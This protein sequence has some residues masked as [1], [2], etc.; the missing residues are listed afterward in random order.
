MLFARVIGSL[1]SVVTV[2]VSI[3]EPVAGISFKPPTKIQVGAAPWSVA[4]QPYG[5][6]LAV[7]CY[8]G[9]NVQIFG[10]LETGSSIYLINDFYVSSPTFVTKNYCWGF[11]WLS[12]GSSPQVWEW[13]SAWPIPYSYAAGPDSRSICFGA[14][15]LGSD[16]ED[17]ALISFG[18]NFV[19][20][21]RGS[22]C[23]LYTD[24]GDFAVGA[25]NLRACAA[26][27]IP[28]PDHLD[29]IAIVLYNTHFVSIYENTSAISGDISFAHSGLYGT[30][31]NPYEICTADF[32]GDGFPDI[33]TADFGAP[34]V[35]V[36]RNLGD[37]T[38]WGAEYGAGIVSQPSC[39]RAADFDNDGKPDLAISN[40]GGGSG[41]VRDVTI[42]RNTGT[43]GYATFAFAGWIDDEGLNA[44]SLCTGD[45]NGDGQIDI[46]VANKL[47]NDVSILINNTRAFACGDADGS[48]AVSIA[49]AV[50][51]I[52]YIFAGGPAPNP[53]AS[54]DADCSGAISIADA[55]YL[56][57]YIFSGGPAPCAA[58]K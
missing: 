31:A 50:Y 33:A 36:L 51:L 22:D 20:V 15:K 47:S 25:G 23:F 43:P 46:A 4:Y 48:S 7:A 57:N 56:I 35:T 21:R 27:F 40:E 38:F 54:G 5:G 11:A 44:S 3:A 45:F 26:N 13:L 2:V 58:C 41:G 9:G 28:D 8:E 30:G 53:L 6:S 12:A 14:F 39:I 16:K 17:A 55:V 32:D 18:L 37:G 19:E 29:D 1:L 10:G 42:L 49:D 34:G 24:W 52:N